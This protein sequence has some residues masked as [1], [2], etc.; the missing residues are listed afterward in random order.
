ML[1]LHQECLLYSLCKQVHRL[2]WHLDPFNILLIEHLTLL[3]WNLHLAPNSSL[4]YYIQ[5]LL[6]T[7]N[8]SYQGAKKAATGFRL[9]WA[10]RR[11]IGDWLGLRR[12]PKQHKI[13]S[14][15]VELKILHF[16]Y[17][18]WNNRIAKFACPIL[19]DPSFITQISIAF[20]AQASNR[21]SNLSQP[22]S[23]KVS[24]QLDKQ[25]T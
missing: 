6:R 2:N 8:E 14:K 25:W 10:A 17:I 19:P 21:V 24:R 22:W 1:R 13:W 4:F 3:V 23:E 12:T 18:L 9:W 5:R 15:N 11:A 16:D 20:F 7:F